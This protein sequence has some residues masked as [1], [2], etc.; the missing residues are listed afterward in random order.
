M[1][2]PAREVALFCLTCGRKSVPRRGEYEPRAVAQ[3]TRCGARGAA[4][5][6]TQA[7]SSGLPSHARSP[8]ARA[9]LPERARSS[10]REDPERPERAGQTNILERG[11][12]APFR[13][14]PERTELEGAAVQARSG[15]APQ[16]FTGGEQLVSELR[17]GS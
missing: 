9:G 16:G 13:S 1:N 7:A 11:P 10:Q 6:R 15:L 12:E 2:G 8:K 17:P 5:P 14:S 4:E 3:L